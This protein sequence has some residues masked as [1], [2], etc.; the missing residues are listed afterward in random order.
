MYQKALDAR[1]RIL[2]HDMTFWSVASMGN[3][4][5]AEGDY[6]VA[7]DYHQK[8]LNGRLQAPGEDHLDTLESFNCLGIV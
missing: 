6:A 5:L 7:E 4:R 2:A 3:L 1:K 8:A